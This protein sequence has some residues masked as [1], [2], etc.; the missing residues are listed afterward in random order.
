ML[1]FPPSLVLL[2]DDIL[3]SGSTCG[4]IVAAKTLS[5]CDCGRQSSDSIHEGQGTPGD[6]RVCSRAGLHVHVVNT[7]KRR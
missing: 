2:S 4:H 3:S 7:V 1:V 5:I 6:L